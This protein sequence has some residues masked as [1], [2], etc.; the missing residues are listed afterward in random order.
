MRGHITSLA[1]LRTHRKMGIA[2]KLMEAAHRAMKSVME[3]EDVTLH[4]RITNRAAT[5]L[6]RDKLNYE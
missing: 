4:V 5:G 6:Y 3:G 1:T 2:S